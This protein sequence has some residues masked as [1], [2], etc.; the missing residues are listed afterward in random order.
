MPYRAL[1]DFNTENIYSELRVATFFYGY[2]LK[3]RFSK[4][5]GIRD[6]DIIKTEKCNSRLC[7]G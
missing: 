2:R 3:L 7:H 5:V 6:K 4:K 1:A